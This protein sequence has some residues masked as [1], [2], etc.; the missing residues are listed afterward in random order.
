M[1]VPKKLWACVEIVNIQMITSPQELWIH[2]D[3]DRENTTLPRSEAALSSVNGK[4][5][6]QWSPLKKVY[7]CWCS[8]NVYFLI[9]NP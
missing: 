5:H 1:E 4:V 9:E 3:A 7:H 6:F 2:E 8:F